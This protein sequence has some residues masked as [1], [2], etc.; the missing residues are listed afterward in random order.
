MDLSDPS[1]MVNG[2]Q[3]RR[4][5]GKKIRTVVRV[6]RVDPSGMIA[7]QTCDNAN[8]TVRAAARSPWD[9]AEIVE[10]I[11]IA[12]G[13]VIREESSCDFGKNFDM[14]NYN[15]LCNLVHGEVHMLFLP[16]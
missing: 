5:A 10:V 9:S 13:D 7:C 2:E 1:P 11:G 15:Q 4:F 12:D 3:L 6:V 8:V 14:S 16:S